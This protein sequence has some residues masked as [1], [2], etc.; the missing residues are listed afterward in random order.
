MN[1]PDSAADDVVL[2][3]LSQVRHASLDQI[4]VYAK[5]PGV[6]INESNREALPFV[7]HMTHILVS[8]A[9]L[10]VTF[11]THFMEA[12][13][14]KLLMS[15]LG[16]VSSTDQVVDFMKEFSNIVAGKT[17]TM[18]E[19]ADFV[20]AQSLPFSIRGY[21]E[22]FYVEGGEGETFIAWGLAVDGIEIH[23]SAAVT[24]RSEA[25]RAKLVDVK[26][27]PEVAAQLGEVEL[28]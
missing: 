16:S 23:C 13:A 10:E 14:A 25:T 7:Q 19:A 12:A 4:R 1:K 3:F 24:L 22:I 6:Q 27:K 9:D 28:F 26:Y 15:K 8:G 18:L 11:K 2:G 21:N 17:K 20:V 5:S